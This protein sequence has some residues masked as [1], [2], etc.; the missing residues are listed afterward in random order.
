MTREN[1]WLESLLYEPSK[2]ISDSEPYT[3]W[4][5]EASPIDKVMIGKHRSGLVSA[6]IPEPSDTGDGSKKRVKK[7]KVICY[8]PGDSTKKK[9]KKV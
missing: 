4:P 5:R 9:K 8:L 6:L 7:S 3:P 2:E 1:A